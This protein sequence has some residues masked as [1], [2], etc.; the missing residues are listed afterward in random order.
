MSSPIRTTPM[1]IDGTHVEAS[2]SSPCT[3]ACCQQG[4]DGKPISKKCHR[5]FGGAS[6]LVATLTNLAESSNKIEKF[7]L[8]TQKKIVE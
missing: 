5:N 3:C 2:P 1:F 4:V 6:N 7:K 8:E